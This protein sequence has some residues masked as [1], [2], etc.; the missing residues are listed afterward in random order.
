MCHQPGHISQN[1]PKKTTVK[2]GNS[3]NSPLAIQHYGMGILGDD[4]QG[5]SPEE[6]LQSNDL[7]ELAC[8]SMTLW[9]EEHSPPVRPRPTPYAMGDP[10]VERAMELLLRESGH[11]PSKNADK[12]PDTE[13][14]LV[15]RVSESE[16][17]IMDREDRRDPELT[18]LTSSLLNPRFCLEGWYSQRVGWLQGYLLREI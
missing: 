9:Y 12:I 7:S 5:R 15:Y 17:A 10:L 18:I 16:H 13:R 3:G 1:C 8:A 11:Y 2:A 14:F 6:L 4:G